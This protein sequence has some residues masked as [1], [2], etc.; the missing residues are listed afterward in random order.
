MEAKELKERLALVCRLLY[1]EGLMDH[2]GLV[3]ARLGPDRLLLNP[4]TMRGTKGRHPGLM[5]PDDLVVTDLLGRKVEGENDPPSETPIFTGVYRARPDVGACYH[6]HL[7]YATLFSM[8]RRRLVTVYNLGAIFGQAVPVHPDANLIQTDPQGRAVAR[9]LG[10]GR[11]VL[12]RS[13]GA[14]LAEADIES[15]FV[16][17]V[18]FEENA[19][20]LYQALQLGPVQA[21]SAAECRRIAE[22]TWHPKVVAKVWDFYLLK[23]REEG[24]V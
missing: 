14:V 17:T 19:R 20:R 21:L 12:L 24:R 11:A 2:A 9:T 1:M 22:R 5:T 10:K 8:G 15:A 23:A 7:P 3:S 16:A 13:H 18:F 6:L 4:R